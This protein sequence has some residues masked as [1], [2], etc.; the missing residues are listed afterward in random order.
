MNKNPIEFVPEKINMQNYFFDESL[1]QKIS[2]AN[3]KILLETFCKILKTFLEAKEKNPALD[4]LQSNREFFAEYKFKTKIHSYIFTGTIDAVFENADG[5]YTVLD[6]KTDSA[7]DEKIYYNQIGCYQ[8]V[9]ADLF[10][11][12]DTSKVSCVLFFAETGEFVDI[13]KNARAAFEKLTDEKIAELLET[14]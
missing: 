4:A 11:A 8:K 9:A 6:Y 7:P 13:T 3:K 14:N 5:S 10:T 1:V 2:E 12:G